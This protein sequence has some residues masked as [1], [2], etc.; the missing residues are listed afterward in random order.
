MSVI[1]TIFASLSSWHFAL[2]HP[3]QTFSRNLPISHKTLYLIFNTSK[4]IHQNKSLLP[5]TYFLL[6]H[7]YQ[8][9]TSARI[10]VMLYKF[11]QRNLLP[12]WVVVSTYLTSV[13]DADCRRGA[14]CPL[15]V[16]IAIQSVNPSA[17]FTLH[18]MQPTPGNKS[19]TDISCTWR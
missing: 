2:T 10:R 19:D 3:G 18:W 12:F 1:L 11:V 4:I 13:I 6:R 9:L 7:P 14:N 16:L 8:H 15:S 5:I 17:L